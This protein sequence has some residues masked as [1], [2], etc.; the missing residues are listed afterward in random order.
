MPSSSTKW[1]SQILSYNVLGPSKRVVDVDADAEV[2]GTEKEV[3]VGVNASAPRRDERN[4]ATV[5]VVEKNILFFCL[6]RY[7]VCKKKIN[8]F[9]W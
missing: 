3:L 6:E 5:A 7:Y 8:Q 4:T 1:S 2:F 9:R